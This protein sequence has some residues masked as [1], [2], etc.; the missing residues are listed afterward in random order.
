M[1]QFY[2]SPYG[3]SGGGTQVGVPVG[4]ADLNA[5]NTFNA[6]ISYKNTNKGSQVGGTVTFNV[7]AGAVQKVTCAGPLTFAFTN[8]GDTAETSAVIVEATNPGAFILTIPGVKWKNPTT[9][10]EY[11][12]IV[13]YLTSLGRNPA[14]FLESGIENMRFWSTTGGAIVYAC[15]L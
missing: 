4:A 2:G 6:N 1:G 12:T 11:L 5:H 8:W 14:T 10:A 13:D 9:G 3:G 7:S 15:L